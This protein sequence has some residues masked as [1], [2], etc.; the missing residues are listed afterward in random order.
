MNRHDRIVRATLIGAGLGLLLGFINT[1]FEGYGERTAILYW[2]D[3]IL[4]GG[5]LGLLC[6]ITAVV[7]DPQPKSTESSEKDEDGS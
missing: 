5:A 3:W 1:T 6:G 4:G 7:R 2:R